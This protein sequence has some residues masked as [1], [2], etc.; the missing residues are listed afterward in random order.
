MTAREFRAFVGLVDYLFLA[1][2]VTRPR[3]EHPLRLRSTVAR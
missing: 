2:G 1:L 3:D